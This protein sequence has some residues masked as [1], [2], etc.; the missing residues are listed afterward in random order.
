LPSNPTTSSSEQPTATLAS[1]ESAL[2]AQRWQ[3]SFEP[4]VEA[5]FEAD[6]GAERRRQL[7]HAGLMALVVYDLFLFNDY[8]ARPEVLQTALYWR[9]GVM[10]LYGLA[11]LAVIHRGLTP[12]WR[13]AGMGSTI[14]VAMVASCMI[15]RHTT[16]PSGAYDPFVFGLIF[17]ACNIVFALR[18]V[19]ALA[20]SALALAV[21]AYF[22]T[23]QPTMPPEAKLFALGLMLATAIFTAQACHRIERSTRHSYLL[24]LREELR[25]QAVLR[26]AGELAVMSQTDALTQLANRRALD[27]MLDQ[28][29]GNAQRLHKPLAALMV[30]IDNFK[31]FNDRFGHL[32]GDDCLR[33][34][35]AAMRGCLREGD[36][37]AR[38]GGEEFVVLIEA[39]SPA[40]AQG[41]AERLRLAVERMGITHGGVAGQSVV[42]VSIG[43]ALACPQPDTASATLIDS[44]DAAMYEAKR[45]GRNR[46]AVAPEVRVACLAPV[47]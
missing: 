7:L 3:L 9:L 2:S 24:I 38:M 27:V 4:A 14:V 8:F 28:R 45:L 20:T 41:A 37:I 18:F 5:R 40:S 29:W 32:A 44:A 1:V 11:V 6:T 15:F 12:P 34:V 35:A 10:T 39:A 43:I 46:W 42:T 13:E 16:S 17:M 36:F 33:N 23:T 30:D 21:A 47:A 25:S 26:T 31:R 22:V 19:T